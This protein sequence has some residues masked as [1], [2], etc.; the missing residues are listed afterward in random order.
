MGHGRRGRSAV[1]MLFARLEPDNVAGT[2]LLD[3]PAFALDPSAAGRDD[4]DLAKRMGVPGGTC[5]GLKGDGVAGRPRRRVCR[6]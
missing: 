5:A 3:R 1:P 2:N 6:K 4:E